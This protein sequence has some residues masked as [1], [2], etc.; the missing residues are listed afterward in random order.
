MRTAHTLHAG[1]GLLIDDLITKERYMSNAQLTHKQHFVPAFYLRA[2]ASDWKDKGFKIKI[3]DK[4]NNEEDYR[5]PEGTSICH[6][7]DFYEKSNTDTDNKIENWLGDIENQVSIV[8][9]GRN[10]SIRTNELIEEFLFVV[11]AKESGDNGKR[12]EFDQKEVLKGIKLIENFNVENAINNIKL[13]MAIQY[14]RTPSALDRFCKQME[15]NENLIKTPFDMIETLQTSGFK[16]RVFK[17]TPS[18]LYIPRKFQ[19]KYRFSTS[20]NPC[21]DYQVNNNL[22]PL[23]ASQIGENDVVMLMPLSPS[24]CIMLFPENF[25]YPGRINQGIGFIKI[26]DM[27]TINIVQQHNN[28]YKEN[29]HNIVVL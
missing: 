25:N 20:D 5:N 9:N 8:R 19:S 2:W 22:Q 10:E 4:K 7:Y 13:F 28:F 29:A 15:L 6:S 14:I 24:I 21:I 27:E 23:F 26:L 3:F 17:L 12:N 16:D 11:H 18:F 1:Y